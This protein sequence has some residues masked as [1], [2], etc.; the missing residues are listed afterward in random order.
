M[1]DS[2]KGKLKI[3]QLTYFMALA[4]LM[5]YMTLYLSS[6]GLTEMQ[7]GV[8]YALG[9][10]GIVLQQWLF[11]RL[12]DRTGRF[13]L[14]S[15]TVMI[16]TALLSALVPHLEKLLPLEFII[17]LL[18]Y[19][20]HKRYGN[21]YNL[22]IYRLRAERPG[23]EFGSTRGMGSLG[24]GLMGLLMGHFIAWGGYR[25]MFG[26]SAI[27]LSISAVLS[28]LVPDPSRKETAE[29]EKASKFKMRGPIAWYFASY[30]VL[31]TA[32][33]VV[34]IFAPLLLER[35]GGGP[36]TYGEIIMLCAIAEVIVFTFWPKIMDK[37]G[38]Q[39]SFISAIAA[40]VVCCLLLSL[41]G[42]IWLFA[43][44]RIS[45]SVSFVMYTLS[46]LEYIDLTVSGNEKGQAI[47]TLSALSS[48]LGYMVSSL[49]GGAVMEHGTPIMM[50]LITMGMNV[51][52]FILHFKAFA[53]M[54]ERH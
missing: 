21:V 18:I 22:W 3:L 52:A 35:I 19:S 27:L 45:L 36:D 40:C 20:F 49:I 34:S 48:G 32:S 24:E 1:K 47:L 23:L 9:S 4:G 11:G 29:K 54:A 39:L 25:M 15:G 10:I 16:C 26:I 44:G 30:L 43:I 12:L 46:H 37:I 50:A 5:N 14:A 8:F 53:G 31:K 28:F 41:S 7:I 17:L 13:R 2:L 33:S 38:Q 51:L 42:R 6:I